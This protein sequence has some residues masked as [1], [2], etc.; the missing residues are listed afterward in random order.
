MAAVIRVALIGGLAA[1]LA[2]VGY[3]RMRSRD[4]RQA[5]Q[6]MAA[7]QEQTEQR[8][9]AK[10]AMIERLNRSRRLAHLRVLD[11][12]S[13]PAGGIL[14]TDL[15][16]IELDDDGRELSRQQF[17]LPG[18]VVFVDAWSIKFHHADV[19]D[20]HPLRGQ[21]L[22]LL[23]RIYSDRMAPVDGYPIDVP[24]TVPPGY[25]VGV[26]ASFET[27]LW[28]HFWDIASDPTLAK[29]MGVRVAQGEAVYKPLRAGRVYELIVDATGGMSLLPLPADEKTAEIPNVG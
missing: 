29:A 27:R 24:G 3:Q 7:L 19:A 14:E 17:T 26:V 2:V 28:E 15:L 22:L 8:L 21:T 18:D 16:F 6:E 4:L 5:M 23:R 9:E 25:A 1:V 12:R 11:Q 20:G 13:D 10:E